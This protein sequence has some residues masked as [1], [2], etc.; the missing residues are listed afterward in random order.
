SLVVR[1]MVDNEDGVLRPGL[2]ARVNLVV[3][4]NN[5]ALQIPEQ[6]LMPQGEKQFV[7]RVVDGKAEMT[8]IKTGLRRSGMVQVV[9]GLSDGDSVVTAGQMKI[10]PG[11][12]VT[13]MPAAGASQ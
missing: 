7:Y 1:A 11:A 5:A 4:S 12:P 8:E 10:Q 13:V 2:F 3:D 9:S 6:A